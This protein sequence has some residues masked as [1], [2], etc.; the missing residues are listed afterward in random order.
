MN[1][2]FTVDDNSLSFFVTMHMT[3][4]NVTLMKFK[5]LSLGEM[6]LI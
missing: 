3:C 4:S 1:V 5:F 2:M 6:R